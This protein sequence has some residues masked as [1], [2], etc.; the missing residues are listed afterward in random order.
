[1]HLRKSA[2]DQIDITVVSDELNGLS[3]D[4]YQRRARPLDPVDYDSIEA[5]IKENADS[6]VFLGVHWQFDCDI[7]VTSGK[8]IADIVASRAY[9]G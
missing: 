8:A 9:T 2:P 5:M 6:R 4:N 3:T 7:G 1:M